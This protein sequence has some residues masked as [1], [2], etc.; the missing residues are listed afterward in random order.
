MEEYGV[1]LELLEQ[2]PAVD[3]LLPDEGQHWVATTFLAR[4]KPGQTPEIREPH[5]CDG[6]GWFAL[7]KLPSPLSKIT[8][9]DLKEYKQ[10]KDE[11]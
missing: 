4:L 7:D 9:A 8:L 3:H 5:K 1:E 11:A 6:I 10:R 2:F